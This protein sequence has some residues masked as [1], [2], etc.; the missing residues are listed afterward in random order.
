MKENE[1]GQYLCLICFIRCFLFYRIWMFWLIYFVNKSRGKDQVK[2]KHALDVKQTAHDV[3]VKH[4]CTF[5]CERF[6]AVIK[7]IKAVSVS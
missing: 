7:A 3:S 6:K 2:H 4:V 5:F 1:H